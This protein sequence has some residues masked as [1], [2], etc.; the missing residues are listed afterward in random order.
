MVRLGFPTPTLVDLAKP[1]PCLFEVIITPATA[2]SLLSSTPPLANRQHSHHPT[3]ASTRAEDLASTAATM[4]SSSP[5]R[6]TKYPPRQARL[7]HGAPPTMR[8]RDISTSIRTP[9][10]RRPRTARTTH[11]ILRRNRT[12]SS[13]RILPPTFHTILLRHRDTRP[14]AGSRPPCNRHIRLKPTIRPLTPTPKD[15]RLTDSKLSGHTMP[16]TRLIGRTARPRVM[17]PHPLASR[18]RRPFLTRNPQLREATIRRSLVRQSVRPVLTSRTLDMTPRCMEIPI[19]KGI[20]P[21][22]ETRPPRLI[23]P[24]IHRPRLCPQFPSIRPTIKPHTLVQLA[25][26]PRPRP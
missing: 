22:V 6:P 2:R 16:L 26:D 7:R 15:R 21:M 5:A 14:L 4:S 3:T 23:R 9:I 13:D 10:R 25:R 18:T 11:S 12:T 1:P 17:L 20:N 8:S 19:N 24:L